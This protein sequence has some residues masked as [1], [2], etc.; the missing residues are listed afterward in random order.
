MSLTDD[1]AGGASGA[2]Y[3]NASESGVTRLR[4]PDKLA[5]SKGSS[6]PNESSA[7]EDEDSR[8]EKDFGELRDDKN[9]TGR[10]GEGKKPPRKPYNGWRG[11]PRS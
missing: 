11:T 2:S 6:D 7:G 1:G 5:D 9:E 8:Y 4:R 10:K 3:G